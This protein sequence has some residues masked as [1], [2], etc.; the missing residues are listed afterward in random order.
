[1]VGALG[2]ERERDREKHTHRDRDRHVTKR[3]RPQQQVRDEVG[4]W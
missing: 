4:R 3:L 2:T 1:M